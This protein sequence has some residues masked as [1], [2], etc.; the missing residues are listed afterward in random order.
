MT[1]YEQ[2]AIISQNLKRLIGR[3]GKDQKQVA[4]DL[5]VKAP[6][7][8]QWV[9]G[10]AVPSVTILQHIAEYFG[11]RLE[12]IVDEQTEK[13]GPDPADVIR[14]PVLGRV[15]AGVPIEMVD[16]II[17]WEERRPDQ[18]P[19]GK[20]FGLVIR[21]D[22]MEPRIHDKDVIIVRQQDDVESGDFAVVAIDGEDATC[23]RVMKYADGIM[24]MPLN[25]NYDPMQFTNEEITEKPVTILG[26]VVESVTKF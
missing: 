20:Y 17:D 11:V 16:E 21:G 25:P 15:A 7:F 5:D 9:T 6:T 3:S 26:K 13:S 2:R 19:K 22:S 18:L 1:D 12:A 8:N 10:K 23:K 14:I 4:F 24:L